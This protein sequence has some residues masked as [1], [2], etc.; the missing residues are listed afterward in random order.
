MPVYRWVILLFVFGALTLNA[1]SLAQNNA[2]LPGSSSRKTGPD[3]RYQIIINIPAFTLYLYQETKLIRTYSIAVGSMVTPSVLGDYTIVNKVINPTWYPEGKEPVPPGPDN[4][5][6]SRWLGLS[7]QGYG[8]HGTNNPESIGKPVSGGCIRMRNQDVEELFSLVPIG[9]PVRFIYETIE[10]RT[11]Y[12]PDWLVVTVYPDIY[13]WGKNSLTAAKE[14]LK[15][16]GI[17]EPIDEQVLAGI[18]K[19]AAGRPELLLLGIDILFAGEI[20]PGRGFIYDGE[21]WVPLEPLAERVRIP[22]E[23]NVLTG[24]LTLANKEVS[25][26]RYWGSRTLVPLR[27]VAPLLGLRWSYTSSPPLLCLEPEDIP[28]KEE[29]GWASRP[30]SLQG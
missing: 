25:A 19:R 14:K 26:I 5:L 7:C 23:W 12:G 8:I 24:T 15:K 18:V 2:I 13:H 3:T 16:A 6:G 1:T 11:D 9:T 28:K 22:I 21:V 17:P 29:H 27:E 20:F 30:P 10:L 4:P